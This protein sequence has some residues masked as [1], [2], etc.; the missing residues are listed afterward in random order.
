MN[1]K[2]SIHGLLTDVH[3]FHNLPQIYY[4]QILVTEELASMVPCSHGCL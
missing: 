3:I 1:W 2:V 4:K